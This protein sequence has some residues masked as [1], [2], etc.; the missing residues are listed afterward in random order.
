MTDAVGGEIAFGNLGHLVQGIANRAAVP[1]QQAQFAVA[2]VNRIT[3]HQQVAQVGR[4][5]GFAL[6]GVAF[7]QEPGHFHRTVGDQYR[8]EIVPVAQSDSHADGYG[9]DV[10]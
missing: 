8:E 7:P 9:V 1:D 6:V 5:A 10:F 2:A 4:G 3:G